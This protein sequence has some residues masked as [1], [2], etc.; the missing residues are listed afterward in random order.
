MGSARFFLDEGQEH[1]DSVV[2][3]PREAR[4]AAE[5]IEQEETRLAGVAG[6]QYRVTE[7]HFQEEV[8]FAVRISSAGM[9]SVDD[10]LASMRDGEITPKEAAQQIAQMRRELNKGRED[11]KNAVAREQATWAEVSKTPAEWQRA[12]ARRAPQLYARAWPA[13]TPDP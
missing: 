10:V 9:E 3:P 11:L 2:L 13:R 6:D 4:R 7:E 1:L 8:E 12:L 5:A